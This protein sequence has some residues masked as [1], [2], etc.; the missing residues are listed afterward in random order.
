MKKLLVA[1]LL[2]MALSLGAALAEKPKVLLD[3]D[4]A[5]Y[6]S[7]EGGALEITLPEGVR[8]HALYLIFCDTPPSLVVS[9]QGADG[10]W[11]TVCEQPEPYYNACVK[12]EGAEK[13][14]LENAREESFS[15]SEIHL[16]GE[17]ELPSW[18]QQRKDF[19]GKAD[20]LVL[21]AHP[22]D[23]F[24]FLGGT[25]PY[26]AGERGKRSSLPI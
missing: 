8:C 1:L 16:F 20:L 25:I 9:V 21:S 24:L 26:C 23:E 2:M 11:Q 5:T 19:T 4:L 17:G 22:D 3:G 6:W 12:L 7:S 13:I 18:V 14:R 10:S 15:I